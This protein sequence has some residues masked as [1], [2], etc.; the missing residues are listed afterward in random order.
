MADT[1]TP[2]HVPTGAW[3]VDRLHSS[4]GFAVEHMGVSLFRGHFTDYDTTLEVTADG[5]RLEGAARVD[6]VDVA[7][8][9]LEAHL[10]SPEF[11]D[12]QRTPEL[13]FS[14][15]D[16]QVDGE[17]L[18]L[19]GEL[20]IRGHTERLEA[21]GT[22]RYVAQDIAGAER[23]GLVLEATVDRRR[24]GLDWNAPLAGGGLALGTDVTLDVRLEL[25]RGA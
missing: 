8:E 4:I 9:N 25:T 11:F 14:S 6:S 24:F 10:A 19:T 13:R 23:V 22:I 12:A 15:T 7:D 18:A 20:T 17:R 16:L 3:Q 21:T 5:A 1:I 2:T